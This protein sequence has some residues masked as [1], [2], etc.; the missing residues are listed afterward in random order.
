M[1]V[2]DIEHE[3]LGAIFCHEAD[4][5]A[6]VDGEL[7]PRD[8]GRLDYGL[9]FDAMRRVYVSGSP[10]DL[11]AVEHELRTME[12]LN[13]AGGAL[14]VGEA[15]RGFSQSFTSLVHLEAH[16]RRVR[17]A[18][19]CR[20]AADRAKAIVGMEAG[21]APID[22]MQREAAK[23]TAEL[24]GRAE[25]HIVPATKGIEDVMERIGRGAQGAGESI[26]LGSRALDD[27]TG[28]ASGGQL[29]IIGGR[30]A[31]GKTSLAMASA[32]GAAR[33]EREAAAAA[34]REARRVM[35]ASLEMPEAELYGR[36]VAT[37]ARINNQK[38]LRP[39]LAA[40]TQDELIAI[41][42]AANELHG[43]PFFVLDMP[44][45]TKL[46]QI[47]GEAKREHAKSP[48]LMLLVDYLQLVGAETRSDS[49]EREVS[50][51]SRGLK[52]LAKELGIPVVALAQL[53]RTLEARG[54]K[55]PM[56]ADL[57][58]SGAIE[59]DADVVVFIYRDEVYNRDTE[60]RGIAEAI[61][62]K[63]RNGPA[64]VVRLRWI[65]E[66]TRFDDLDDAGDFA[67]RQSMTRTRRPAV[68]RPSHVAA[69]PDADILDALDPEGDGLPGADDT[70][71]ALEW[72]AERAALDLGPQDA[73][74]AA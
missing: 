50:E 45:G 27:L 30:P 6:L 34:R 31:M 57:R 39:H 47:R 63:Q 60:A 72:E 4:A 28:G 41:T 25:R 32:L 19:Q 33:H 3:V 56:L 14:G 7:E 10:L 42:A 17:E 11:L 38:I 46:S 74:G 59:Q 5:F 53:S 62:A 44:A 67:P 24:T 65:R 68:D 9:I 48:L 64:D 55:R 8:F 29:I 58:E 12:R 36:A 18:A 40:M 54:D 61:V 66:S 1:R 70:P 69:R 35:F 16:A 49:R 37:T 23:L 26:T 15:L 52:A 2:D 21:N 22:A 20:R 51:V 43:L 73:A 13:S 71:T